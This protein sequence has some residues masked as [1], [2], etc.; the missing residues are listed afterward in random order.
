MCL[1]ANLNFSVE[2]VNI[3]FIIQVFSSLG[4]DVV[5]SAFD[6]YNVCIFAYGQTGSGKTYT[7]MG[8]KEEPGMSILCFAMFKDHF[9]FLSEAQASGLP[10]MLRK[11]MFFIA[12]IS[13]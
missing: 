7:M 8:S 4:E 3:F 5:Q 1:V 9:T 11:V 13:C 2:D 10:T 6:G 12:V